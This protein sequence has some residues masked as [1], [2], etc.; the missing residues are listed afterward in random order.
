[1]HALRSLTASE[2]YWQ[3]IRKARLR[4]ERNLRRWIA[5]EIPYLPQV[6]ERGAI[7]AEIDRLIQALSVEPSNSGGET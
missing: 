4:G 2:R 1:M 6:D 7:I 3:A 5:G